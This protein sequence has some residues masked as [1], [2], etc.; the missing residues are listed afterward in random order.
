LW[1]DVGRIFGAA[2][3]SELVMP[4][5]P[6]SAALP[7]VEPVGVV[8]AVQMVIWTFAAWTRSWMLEG[9][10]ETTVMSHV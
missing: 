6:Y 8:I 10:A 7:H 9:C 5:A 3:A 1:P 4:M 2:L